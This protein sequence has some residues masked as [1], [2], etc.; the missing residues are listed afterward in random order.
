MSQK[1][2]RRIVGLFLSFMKRTKRNIDFSSFEK[3]KLNIKMDDPDD[4]DYVKSVMPENVLPS[5]IDYSEFVTVKNQGEIGSCG[6]MAAVT[7]LEML[8]LMHDYKH[9]G[10]PLSERFHYYEVRQPA[11]FDTFPKDS[12]QT[13]RYAM[14]VLFKEGVCPEKLCRYS[15]KDYNVAPGSFA[16]GFARFWK[17]QYYERCYSIQAVKSALA[18]K[19]A[20]WMGMAVTTD[21]YY[22]RGEVLV[23][24]P[25]KP[26]AGGHAMLVIGYDDDKGA[27]K[28]VNSW[29]EQWG[30][31]GFGWIGYEYWAKSPWI[32][33][34]SYTL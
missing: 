6:S 20:V 25:K 8:E 16:Y 22:N 13:G 28:V 32:D 30:D 1:L 26:S 17:I 34:Y 24:D 12:G 4:R 9:K 14:S 3:Y 10:V 21:I 15:Q 31:K 29:G 5:N 33:V 19:K 7:G 23:Y 11:Y 27:L 2:W 18:E